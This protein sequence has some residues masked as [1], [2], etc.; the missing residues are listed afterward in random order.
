MAPTINEQLRSKL[1]EATQKAEIASQRVSFLDGVAFGLREA[2]E[3]A[4]PDATELRAALA[5]YLAET[6]PERAHHYEDNPYETPTV[7]AA[8]HD[9]GYDLR[10]I[11]EAYDARSADEATKDR[12]PDGVDRLFAR[13]NL[14]PPLAEF[15][16]EVRDHIEAC[17][18]EYGYLKALPDSD[19][20]RLGRIIRVTSCQDTF[21]RV[22]RRLAE[23]LGAP[24]RP[25]GGVDDA[26]GE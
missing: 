25:K 18:N 19:R 21:E 2:L 10:N 5:T 3:V 9:V 8:L 15:Y 22:A 11:L 12:S 1:K 16:A 20:D 7:D 6:L 24:Y 13:E 4:P 23:I 26:A 17:R 14:R